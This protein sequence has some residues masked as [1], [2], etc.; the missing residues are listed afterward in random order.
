MQNV[1]SMMSN[2]TE[3]KTA[4]I[5]G[6]LTIEVIL[7]VFVFIYPVLKPVP[8]GVDSAVYINDV[9]WLVDN[10]TVPKPNQNTYHGSSSYL[11]PMTDLNISILNIITGLDVVSPLFSIYQILLIAL[12]VLSSYLVGKIYGNLTAILLP[13]TVMASFSLIRLFIGS[14]VSNLLAFVYMNVIYYLSFRYYITK[15][16]VH[17]LLI[18]LL[19]ISLFLTHN[20]LSAP[21]FVATFLLYAL[22]LIFIDNDL[23]YQVKKMFLSVNVSIRY[24]GLFIIGGLLFYLCMIYIPVFKVAKFAFWQNDTV[25]KFRGAITLSQFSTYLGPFVYTFAILGILFYFLN[26]KKNILSFRLLPFLYTFVL[27]ILL[28]TSRLGINFFYERLVF[29]GAIM[30]ALFATYFF[31]HIV[32]RLDNTRYPII[33]ALF[34]TLVIPSGVNQAK[35]LYDNSNKI[36]LPQIEALKLLKSVSTIDDV[37]YSNDNAVSGTY[38]DSI[39]SDRYIVYFSTTL[40]RCIENDIRCVSFNTP[41]MNDSKQYFKEN[42]VK[43]FLFMKN[44]QEGNSVLDQLITKYRDAGYLELYLEKNVSLFELK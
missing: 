18:I 9:H 6:L 23:R 36:T 17:I 19:F 10:Q 1:F 44:S 2:K 32:L 26:F 24:I 15:K 30:I 13:I 29:L 8:P 37:V 40:N 16:F 21:I 14:T 31:S 27:L 25:D 42:G 34:L 11:A 22:I 39:V 33:I 38:H 4:I 35:T 20:Y 28:Q 41:E 5:I 3:N 12:I 7:S 43:F